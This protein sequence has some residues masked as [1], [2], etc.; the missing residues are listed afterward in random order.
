MK[1]ILRTGGFLLLVCAVAASLLAVTE[2]ITAPRI[3]EFQIQSLL[4]AKKFVL[5]NAA[6]FK[7]VSFAMQNAT[8]ETATRTI[9]IAL[10]SDGTPVGY[11]VQ[12]APKGYAGPIELVIGLNPD[13]TISGV[14]I[15]SMR[16]T[17]GLGTKLADKFMTDFLQACKTVGKTLRFKVKK[18]GGD[19]DAITA[20]T[21]SSRAF[22]TGIR[23][24]VDRAQKY[25]AIAGGQK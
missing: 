13:L 17:P 16:E 10:A 1:E 18:D 23:E 8:G 20:A 22:C 6:Q 2:Q 24:G 12:T 3:K 5:A 7:P 11:V 21:I 9:D 14:K 15:Q 19:I 4:K 25:L